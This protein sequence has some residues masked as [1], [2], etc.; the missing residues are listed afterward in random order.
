MRPSYRRLNRAGFMQD[1]MVVNSDAG[2]SVDLSKD[3][4]KGLGDLF[5]CFT[6][7]F[8]KQVKERGM[9]PVLVSDCFM[10]SG[11]RHKQAIIR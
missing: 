1:F 5:A 4:L 2:T 10:S 3:Q 9:Y 6:T 7:A 11:G 8:L